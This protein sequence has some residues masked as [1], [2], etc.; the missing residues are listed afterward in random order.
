MNDLIPFGARVFVGQKAGT[1]VATSKTHYGVMDMTG[2]VNYYRH[3]EVT[4]HG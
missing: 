3:A 1:I 4:A 2:E